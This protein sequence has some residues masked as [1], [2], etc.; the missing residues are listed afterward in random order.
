LVIKFT[1]RTFKFTHGNRRKI[2][3]GPIGFI[4]HPQLQA[5]QF[6]V[7]GKWCR[8]RHRFIQSCPSPQSPFG[9]RDENEKVLS[10]SG[11]KVIL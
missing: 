2:E 8:T 4:D 11:H 6:S 7:Q 10:H 1:K 5:N 9:S 3:P